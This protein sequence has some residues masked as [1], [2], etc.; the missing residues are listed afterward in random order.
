MK[1]HRTKT[2]HVPCFGKVFL[3]ELFIFVIVH[4]MKN[5][6]YCAIQCPLLL[7]LVNSLF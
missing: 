5:C 4:A 1:H 2:V 6:F 7:L 3:G